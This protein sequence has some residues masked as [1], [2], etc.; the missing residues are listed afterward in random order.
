MTAEE[1]NGA[2]RNLWLVLL[3]MLLAGIAAGSYLWISQ[4]DLL[5]IEKIVVDGNRMVTTEEI[6]DKTGPMLRG[7]SL[8]SPSFDNASRSLYDFPFI[9]SVELDRD[10][11]HSMII[12]IREYR[13]FVTLAVAEGRYFMLSSGGKA[14]AALP[15][16]D[17]GYPLITTGEP[18]QVD[19]GLQV[20]CPDAL[21][22]YEFLNNIPTNFNQEIAEVR[23]VDGDVTIRTGSGVNVHFGALDDYGLKFEV[24]RQLLAKS[25]AAG[26][27]LS[28]D[29]SVVERPVTKDGTTAPAMT[30]TTATT[31]ANGG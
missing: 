17:P 16:P 11:P 3:G 22:G 8:V 2:R 12:H 4:S 14:L 7:R 29:V 18:C 15:A 26:T 21:A 9:E 1:G 20:E 10:F 19:I 28:I 25:A 30:T 27:T 6:I 31:E 23:V 13:P 24:L 5:A